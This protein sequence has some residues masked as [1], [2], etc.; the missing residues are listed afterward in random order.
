MA[1][2]KV[3]AAGVISLNLAGISP[4]R[5]GSNLKVVTR[6]YMGASF[7][8]LR[9]EQVDVPMLALW[10]GETAATTGLKLTGLATGAAS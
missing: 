2:G 7:M 10:L 1:P 8:S 3:R 5:A 9:T 4:R 6:A